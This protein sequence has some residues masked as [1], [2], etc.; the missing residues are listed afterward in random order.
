MR[1]VVFFSFIINLIRR[2]IFQSCFQLFLLCMQIEATDYSVLQTIYSIVKGHSQP[3]KYQ[4]HPRELILRSTHDWSA[5]QS[6]LVVL[7]NEGAVVTRGHLDTLQISLTIQG[8]EMCQAL[9][10]A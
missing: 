9:K 4:L 8:L 10:T 6:S 2:L 1:L 7:E 3:L 5:I